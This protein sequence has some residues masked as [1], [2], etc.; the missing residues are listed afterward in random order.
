MLSELKKHLFTYSFKHYTVDCFEE[1]AFDCQNRKH[2]PGSNGCLSPSVIC[3]GKQDCRNNNDENFCGLKSE[4]I[5][6]SLNSLVSNSR[7]Q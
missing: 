5:F 3:D 4:Y 2:F 7:K 1:N 6:S